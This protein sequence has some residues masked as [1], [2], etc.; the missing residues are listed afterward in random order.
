MLPLIAV[1]F[2]YSFDF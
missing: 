1:E 2:S